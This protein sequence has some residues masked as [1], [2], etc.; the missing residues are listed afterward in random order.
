MKRLAQRGKTT[1]RKLQAKPVAR[2]AR[3]RDRHERQ[4]EE[5]ARR[6][7]AGQTGLARLLTPAPAAGFT[8]PA[9]PGT[10]LAVGIRT[11]LETAFGA[12]LTALRVHRDTRA[13]EAA[14]TLAAR[15]FASGNHLFFAAGRF[16]PD[17]LPGRALLAHEV[18]HALQQTSVG[19]SRGISSVL[20][21]NGSGAIQL[22]GDD[23]E[24]SPL[25]P[26]RA[27]PADLDFYKLAHIHQTAYPNNDL[28]RQLFASFA[29]S[30]QSCASK[31]E[32]EQ[33]WAEQDT[34]LSQ[35][36]GILLEPA[37][38]Q[39]YCLL[40]DWLKWKGFYTGAAALAEK[41]PSYKTARFDTKIYPALLDRDL[42][43]MA[44]V[45]I[46]HPFFQPYGP[47]Q[48][49]NTYS[50]Y[51]FGTTRDLQNLGVQ[52]RFEK[53]V[54]TFLAARDQAAGTSPLVEAEPVYYLAWAL[55][56]ADK[57]RLAH[58]AKIVAKVAPGV[59]TSRLTAW[60]RMQVAQQIVEWAKN[61]ASGKG[62]DN[63]PLMVKRIFIDL[64]GPIQ[65]VAAMAHKYWNF[66]SETLLVLRSG[67]MA[68][69]AGNVMAIMGKE[70]NKPEYKAFHT[71]VFP[72][73]R[74]L[75][76][77]D[78]EGDPLPTP[79]YDKARQT[80]ITTIRNGAA[81]SF[82]GKLLQA[83]QQIDTTKLDLDALVTY[84]V[85]L[86]IAALLVELLDSY[87]PKADEAYGQAYKYGDKPA[88]DI[89]IRHRLQ[90]ARFL[91]NVG[92]MLQWQD[93]SDLADEVIV[94]RQAGQQSSF[95]ALLED[96]QEEEDVHLSRLL[97]D[98]VPNAELSG[99]QPLRA[100][101][102]HRFFQTEY[103]QRLN[104]ALER[105]LDQTYVL[106][107]RSI[108]RS[109]N[110]EVLADLPRPKRF[111]IPSSGIERAIRSG[112][113]ESYGA[114]LLAHPKTRELIAREQARQTEPVMP[115]TQDTLE[116]E[117]PFLWFF[118]SLTG[119][120]TR[121]RRIAA[122]NLLVHESPEFV[123]E[124]GWQPGMPRNLAAVDSLPANRWL[125]YFAAQM[126][127]TPVD[128]RG[129]ALEKPLVAIRQTTET[130]YQQEHQ[131]LIANLRKASIRDRS[132]RGLGQVLP[133]LQA[134]SPYQA[135][136][137]VQ[138][139]PG[140]SGAAFSIQIPGVVAGL[141]L[142][143]SNGTEPASERVLHH[144]ALMLQVAPS[145]L[146]RLG[147]RPKVET[148][149]LL[150]PQ[151]AQ[152]LKTIGSRRELLVQVLTE[153]E[154]QT[155]N[156]IASREIALKTLEEAFKTKLAKEQLGFGVMGLKNATGT[157][158]LKSVGHG[159]VIASGEEDPFVITDAKTGMQL[160]WKLVAIDRSFAYYPAL[161]PKSA[162]LWSL[163]QAGEPDGPLAP[164]LAL[165]T[166]LINGQQR[167]LTGNSQTELDMLTY[168]VTMEVMKR[169]L[170]ELGELLQQFGELTMDVLEMV[171][172]MQPLIAARMVMALFAFV[173][174]PDFQ[175]IKKTITDNPQ[176]VL[177]ELFGR[178]TTFV[179]PAMLWEFLLFADTSMLNQLHG[180]KI[181]KSPK[182]RKGG[183]TARLLRVL[184][185]LF[186]FSEEVVGD[187]ARYQTWMRWQ[188]ESV[189]MFVLRRPALSTVLHLIALYF[190]QIVAF[191]STVAEYLQSD[192]KHQDDMVH[193]LQDWPDT[194]HKLVLRVS[195]MQL[196]DEV[197]PMGE[198][199]E[200]LVELIISRLGA[201]Y[202]MGANVVLYLLRL[203]GKE[204][205]VFDFLA[206]QIPAELNPNTYWRKEV[207]EP[208]HEKLDE[209]GKA[210]AK[211]VFAF[212]A[213]SLPTIGALSDQS[214]RFAAFGKNVDAEFA[215]RRAKEAAAQKAEE[216]QPYGWHTGVQPRKA[217]L[218]G[219]LGTAL[220]T[221]QRDAAEHWFGQDFS[222][223][224]LHRDASSSRYTQTVAAAAVTAGSHIFLHP[225]VDVASSLGQHVLRH[226]LAHVVQQ[227][228]PRMA[229]QPQDRTPVPPLSGGGLRFNPSLEA[230]A[231]TAAT[232]PHQ[233][234]SSRRRIGVHPI[235]LAD[236][237]RRFL[238]HITSGVDLETK[239][240][241]GDTARVDKIP[242]SVAPRLRGFVD[243]FELAV[244]SH[245]VTPRPFDKVVT[246]IKNHLDDKATATGSRG[247]EVKAAVHQAILD[248]IRETG[249]ERQKDGSDKPLY[250][251][252]KQRL[253]V[254]LSRRI[255]GITGIDLDITLVE[256]KKG[257]GPVKV[258]ELKVQYIHLAIIHGN[259]PL[260]RKLTPPIEPELVPMLRGVLFDEGISLGVWDKTK[261]ALTR[262]I[263]E[264]AKKMK[265]L[266]GT[267]SVQPGQ[268]PSV[269]EYVA[270]APS[271]SGPQIGLRLGTYNDAGGGSQTGPDRESHHTSQFL[272]VEFFANEATEQAFPLLDQ[273]PALFPGVTP[274]TS[275]SNRVNT[276]ADATTI[277]IN[278]QFQGRGG[279]MP[280]ILLSKPAHHMP[281]LHMTPNLDDLKDHKKSQAGVVKARF[282]QSLGKYKPLTENDP[283][284][285]HFA[286]KTWNKKQTQKAIYEATIATYQ[287][288][289]EGRM[290]NALK[291][292]LAGPERTYYNSLAEL[293]QD[294]NQGERMTPQMALNVWTKAVQRNDASMADKGWK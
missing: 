135:L 71:A 132:Q 62:L 93:L 84:G 237:S 278:A 80:A 195:D 265:E 285:L 186:N 221:P 213:E 91:W 50:A 92:Q 168:A 96:W 13:A 156:W 273:Y 182:L 124:I 271:G 291:L 128:Q 183:A 216:Q 275:P 86:N 47:K 178:L 49:V 180:K 254:S 167:I 289:W 161:G 42:S 41:L 191:V 140:V 276:I 120:I 109:A 269:S 18:G 294:D 179:E 37:Q 21:A 98:I 39:K 256:E 25:E 261:Y 228:G 143:I 148:A 110:A 155:D 192:P 281:G 166:V 2:A 149:V 15:A 16:A 100:R 199:V 226:E 245:L 284:T 193:G 22:A 89:R 162:E 222:H 131:R 211:A 58:M 56:E 28:L 8:L 210:F 189:E 246:D 141:L 234:I 139:P 174:S 170:D 77:L 54:D 29:A 287:A 32:E 69:A 14:H 36:P 247:K 208:L 105:K 251:L 230:E 5:V 201:K 127:T 17:T 209:A 164:D 154:R 88:A 240:A 187:F 60:Q 11:E 87:S 10:P 159:F 227:T 40:I 27:I 55:R 104:A 26:I 181:E 9:S 153:E 146:E 90:L 152:V 258:V 282:E 103:Y 206:A 70:L 279:I 75:L 277:E 97:D 45:W 241:L 121:F 272:L 95:L 290:K 4:A 200:A 205:E 215:T 242:P 3:Q 169:Q 218:P 117:S 203:I 134:Y 224:R 253:A 99:W 119:L 44:E 283:T 185:K 177:A 184:N 23:L 130:G 262:H 225:A 264:K 144:A 236:I 249:K 286:A 122:F 235:T 64:S 76:A 223:V 123:K 118:P 160:S 65:Q 59:G 263:I 133:L 173:A 126:A 57:H 239:Q 259:S 129:E 111:F 175:E 255:L 260:W 52:N 194:V 147:G 43:W 94:A 107:D 176:K 112:V 113:R 67:P 268:L 51:L 212:M 53:A 125:G 280:C 293:R 142:S 79:Q 172:G 165:A 204:Q 81:R 231:E 73:L 101:D 20:P 267:P 1:G 102:L 197:L 163:N 202:K 266:G 74:S 220:P 151:L 233:P 31:A 61:L 106:E 30:L 33:F 196:P 219:G 171:P 198:L 108:I 157:Q 116:A 250:K 150:L 68:E 158:I 238:T 288:V 274:M 244:K 243:S 46:R 145:M 270:T 207:K 190:D 24:K 35:I 137:K 38:Q 34:L 136:S 66:V 85:M 188:A 83:M 78:S 19:T 6:F 214:A 257:T 114:L 82:E 248:A 252:D 138:A 7:V 48:F 217:R 229:G 232:N 72:A 292:A 63:A 115:L 12:D